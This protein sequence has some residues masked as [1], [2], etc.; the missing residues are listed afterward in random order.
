MMLE[1]SYDL[2][3]K[4]EVFSLENQWLFLNILDR[5]NRYI[6]ND[7][8]HQLGWLRHLG[9]TKKIKGG[10]DPTRAG[11]GYKPTSITHH[12][13]T[14]RNRTI[15]GKPQRRIL[16]TFFQQDSCTLLLLVFSLRLSQNSTILLHQKVTDYH[17]NAI[18]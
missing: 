4:L 2:M 15:M 8:K 11:D 10:R 9:M 12:T 18:C 13:T 16:K 3:V 1:L 17:C 6:C 14:I 7:R 5:L